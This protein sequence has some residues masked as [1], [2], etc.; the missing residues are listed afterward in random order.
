MNAPRA[1]RDGE[2]GQ[3]LVIVAGGAVALVLL[4]GLVLDVGVAVFNRRDG[5]N[6][7]DLMAL[8]GTKFVA[9]VHQNKPDADPSVTSTYLALN[10]TALANDCQAAGAVP[11]TWKAWFVGDVGL[12]DISPILSAAD[13][14]PGNALGVRVEV[15]RKPGTFI[16]GSIG[17]ANWNVGTQATAIAESPTTVKV[18]TSGL[19]P[20]AY[21][22]D[23]SGP[24]QPGQVYDLTD[25]KD[26]PGGFGYIAWTG[27][28]DPNSLA[29]SICTPNNPEFY[30]PKWFPGDPGKSNSSSVRACLDQWIASG[31]TVLI[32]MYD[33]TTGNGNNAQ[34]HIIGIAAFVLTSRAQPAV[35][36]IRG[37]FVNIYPYTEPVPGGTSGNPSTPPSP[38]D[39]SFFLGLVR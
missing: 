26:L 32:P 4:M 9:D 29:T 36:N 1:P 22:A 5:Q 34:Y 35:D 12:P 6:T 14:V 31:Q 27:T 15:T 7:S 37:Y 30:L 25:G 39:T 23:P 13:A 33:Q 3:I 16:I 11:C 10:K 18:G 38:T 2:R 28:N 8:A 21:K 24:F 20:I 17:I 19:L